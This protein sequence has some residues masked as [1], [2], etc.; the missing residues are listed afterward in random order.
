MKK[1]SSLS[2]W[3]DDYHEMPKAVDTCNSSA[4][5]QTVQ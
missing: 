1:Q 2:A 5:D 4:M 3:L